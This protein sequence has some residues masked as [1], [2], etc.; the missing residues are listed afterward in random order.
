[1]NIE[2]REAKPDEFAGI[3]ALVQTCYGS[4]AEPPEWW[5]WRHFELDPKDS[6]M[7]V[8]SHNNTIVGMRPMA[9]FDYFLQGTQVRGALF[10]AVM[11]HPDYR[12][13]GIFS[14]L[15]KACMDEAW[16]RGARFVNT[17][18]NDI[19]FLGFMKLGWR[20]P[21]ERT[22]L[23]RPINLTGLGRQK[24]RPLWLGNVLGL[25]AQGFVRLIAPHPTQAPIA[26]NT[27]PEL[28]VEAG[29]LSRRIGVGYDGLILHRTHAWLTWRYKSNPWN[30]YA[31]FE[32]RSAEGTLVG[33]AVTNMGTQ[34]GI[35][36]GYIVDLLGETSEAR[37]ALIEASIARLRDQGAQISIAVMSS[38][39]LVA[40]LRSQGFFPVPR[41]ISP[42]K[43][44]TVYQPH[45][46]YEATF[47][48]V[49]SIDRW[50]QTLGDWDGI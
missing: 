39:A 40:D 17:M 44:Y 12:R 35:A 23:V 25:M 42:K 6:T 33:F 19:S 28:S 24:V 2:I 16:R 11:V 7:F 21:G 22:L 41:R 43:F 36:I 18:P 4:A 50:Y 48:S 34:K 9:L 14:R 49:A 27:V 29:D 47:D 30:C 46:N 1:M 15:V 13:L 10:S 5:R 20:D 38:P 3:M 8:A 32:A 31:R 26:I 45:S 37:Q